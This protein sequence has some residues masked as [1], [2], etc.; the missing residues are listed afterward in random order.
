MTELQIILT[1]IVKARGCISGFKEGIKLNNPDFEKGNVTLQ[2]EMVYSMVASI[3]GNLFNAESWLGE[4]I[5]QEPT[6]NSFENVKKKFIEDK[7]HGS[8]G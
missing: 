4:V 7:D 8:E 5:G 6:N 3:D 2:F 1:E